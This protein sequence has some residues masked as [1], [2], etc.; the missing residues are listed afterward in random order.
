MAVTRVKTT[1]LSKLEASFPDRLNPSAHWDYYNG[2]QI[3]KETVRSRVVFKEHAFLGAQRRT[4]NLYIEVRQAITS[5][6]MRF[7]A[8]FNAFPHRIFM[9]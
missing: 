1:A 3:S 2:L 8:K 6:E 7:S 4:G 5:N 9:T